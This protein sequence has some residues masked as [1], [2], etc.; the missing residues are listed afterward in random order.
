MH[1]STG[2]FRPGTLLIES[3]LRAFL[4]LLAWEQAGAELVAGAAAAVVAAGCVFV[5]VVP[6]AVG[7]SA[8]AA[9]VLAH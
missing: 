3:L 4:S 2:R 9:A 6:S 7:A 1:L 5:P 8:L